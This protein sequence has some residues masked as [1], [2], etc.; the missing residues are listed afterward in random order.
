MTRP[1]DHPLG[2]LTSC[3]GGAAGVTLPAQP[4]AS[5]TGSELRML[6]IHTAVSNA[7]LVFDELKFYFFNNESISG[8][9]QEN[10]IFRI[11]D[12]RKS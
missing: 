4:T 3:P 5:H 11:K 7:I 9:K 2:A 1:L 8:K 10:S 6:K 12:R